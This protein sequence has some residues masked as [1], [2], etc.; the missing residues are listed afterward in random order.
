M[1][2]AHF[3]TFSNRK[4]DPQTIHLPL[5]AYTR[6]GGVT[7]AATATAP[8]VPESASVDITALLTTALATAARNGQAVPSQISTDEETRGVVTTTGK[9]LVLVYG[10]NGQKLEDDSSEVYGRITSGGAAPNLTYTVTFYTK[11]DTGAETAAN[12]PNGTIDLEL[13]Y[14]FDLHE[15]PS[16]ALVAVKGRNVREELSSMALQEEELIIVTD[17]NNAGETTIPNLANAPN[18]TSPIWMNY[19]GWMTALNGNVSAITVDATGQFTVDET[20]MGY[21]LPLGETVTVYY[22]QA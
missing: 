18:I 21:T 10:A 12:L 3:P 4:Q 16:D 9:N 7:L 17:P 11:D 5:V 15:L 20:A 1:A 13:P 8:A 6:V 14:R 19:R 22:Y 2:T